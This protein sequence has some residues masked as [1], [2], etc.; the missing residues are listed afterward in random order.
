MRKCPSAMLP[1]QV[2]RWPCPRLGSETVCLL[3]LATLFVRFT[4]PS[5]TPLSSTCR[6]SAVL[7]CAFTLYS[8]YGRTAA[9]WTRTVDGTLRAACHAPMAVSQEPA[10]ARDVIGAAIKSSSPESCESGAAG[11]R[12]GI[13]SV[14]E[15]YLLAFSVQR[16]MNIDF[17][18]GREKYLAK[19]QKHNGTVS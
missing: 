10:R 8:T 15:V 11:E 6:P 17:G 13:A 18:A 16:P 4:S 2:L 3:I 7:M 19:T 9:L 1:R 14:R 12:Y 5:P